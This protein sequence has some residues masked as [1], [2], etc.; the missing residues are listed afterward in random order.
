MSK[1]LST[2]L[3]LLSLVSHLNAISLEGKIIDAKTKAPIPF[4]NIGLKNTAYGT[5]SNSLGYFI[6]NLPEKGLGDTLYFSCIG[7][8]TK[9]ISVPTYIRPVTIQLQPVAIPLNE[10]RVMPDR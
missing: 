6:F 8:Q 2:S 9:A 10:V 4:V 3:F 5:A 1:F 7:Y